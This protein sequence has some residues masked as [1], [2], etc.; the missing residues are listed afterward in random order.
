MLSLFPAVK[1]D[2]LAMFPYAQQSGSVFRFSV[3]LRHVESMQMTAEQM[4]QYA[5][6]RSIAQSGPHQISVDGYGVAIAEVQC[7]YAGQLPENG[8]E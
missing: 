1:R 8:D 5:A 3:L 2:L 6:Q 4:S 7:V